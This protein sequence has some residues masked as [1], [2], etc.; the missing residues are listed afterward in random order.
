[1]AVYFFLG[2]KDILKE[3]FDK[4][5]EDIERMDQIKGAIPIDKLWK[6][7][8]VPID[9]SKIDLVWLMDY[10]LGRYDMMIEEI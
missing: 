9:N 4:Y 5:S 10:Y 2:K 1:M 6:E 8:K 3:T 7:E